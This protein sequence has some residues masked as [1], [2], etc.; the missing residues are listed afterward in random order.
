MSVFPYTETWQL[1]KAAV[2]SE[3]GLVVTQNHIA[4]DVGASGRPEM[5]GCQSRSPC[6]FDP[7]LAPNKSDCSLSGFDN[8]IFNL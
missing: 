2:Q 6:E 4:S 3:Y 5:G 1:R 8:L 7:P